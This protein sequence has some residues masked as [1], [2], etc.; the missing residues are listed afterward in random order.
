MDDTTDPTE[1]TAAGPTTAHHG[2]VTLI[3]S[4]DVPEGRDDA[5]VELWTGTSRY[6]RQQVGYRSLRL[7][8]AL[9]PTARYRYV[10]V[11]RWA[12]AEEFATAHQSD[13]F[14]D[15]VGQPAWKEFPSNPS[16]YEVI[17]EH[18]A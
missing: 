8:R 6:F 12:S 16:L 18:D 7:H 2:P 4:F 10:N 11:A 13:E 14:F 15:L 3:N 9:S 17:V 1:R 5:F